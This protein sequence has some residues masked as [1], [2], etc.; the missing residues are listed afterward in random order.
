MSSEQN[1]ND[2][3]KENKRLSEENKKNKE[4]G[5]KRNNDLDKFNSLID[6]AAEAITCDAN[7]QKQKKIDELKQKYINAQSN[8]ARGPQQLE[9]ARK[10]YVIYNK[11][12][13]VY[14]ELVEMELTKKATMIST[15][16]KD[17]FNEE[18]QNVLSNVK[19]YSGL[20]SNLKNV[21]ELYLK[22][23]QENIELTKKLKDETNDILTN[24][25]KTYYQDQGIDNLKFYY[26]YFLLIVY[27][28]CVILF[29][30]FNFIYPSQMSWK[31]RAGILVILV[32][33]PF[34]STWILGKLVM[35]IYSIYG[36]LPTN[37]HKTL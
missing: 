15:F 31:I 26:Y 1:Y 28:I 29:G 25:R 24:E 8:L 36:L 4:R 27:V 12:E 3:L 30:V 19:T 34:I 10:N 11:G 18:S 32:I 33:L 5:N 9:I 6:Q 14:N 7:C 22:Y 37:I 13:P 20:L 17:N 21:F 2:L 16:Y 35:M 23:K